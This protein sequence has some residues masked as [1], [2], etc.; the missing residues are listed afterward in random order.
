MKTLTATVVGLVAVLGTGNG[1][2]IIALSAFIFVL[3]F[4]DAYYLSKE[5]SFRAHYDVFVSEL[6][7]DKFKLVELFIVKKPEVTFRSLVNAY[8]SPAVW[9]FYF[10]VLCFTVIFWIFKSCS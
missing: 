8:R 4:L 7:A 6:H 5:K 2:Q 10:A 3:S 1:I 9:V